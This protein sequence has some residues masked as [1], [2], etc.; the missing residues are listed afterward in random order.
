MYRDKIKEIQTKKQKQKF[1]KPSKDSIILALSALTIASVSV[2]SLQENKIHKEEER[3]SRLE[4]EY[5]G[6]K[7][8]ASDELILRD[9][10]IKGYQSRLD[11]KIKEID[12]LTEELKQKERLTS[13]NKLKSKSAN[14]TGTPIT[15]TLTF[16]G[17]GAD[18]NGG[19]EGI[20]A[21]GQKLSG[22]FAA[23]NHYAR[24]TK[25]ILTTGQTLNVQDRGGSSFNDPNRLDVFVPR[26]DGE[27]SKDYKE[28]LKLYGVRKVKA[29]KQ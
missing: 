8:A 9:E 16:Y 28:R 4:Q 10:V 12:K 7:N 23:S 2:V 15:L 22:G 13:N 11:E 14:P 5:S 1:F 26:K 24:G 20:T 25:F 18:E 19:Y 29:Y 27:T 17:D 3:Y 6:Y 21:Y